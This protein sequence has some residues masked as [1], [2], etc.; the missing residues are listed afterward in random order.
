MP[1]NEWSDDILIA[2]LN[3][4]PAFL[5]TISP[6]A[7]HTIGLMLAAWRRVPGAHDAASRGEWNRRPWGAPRMF[8]RM[9]LGLVGY[10]RLGRKVARIAGAMEMDVAFYNPAVDGSA[11]ASAPCMAW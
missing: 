9:R 2:E 8:S 11:A 6:T 10:G 4:E 7:E 1:L 5:E 3:D